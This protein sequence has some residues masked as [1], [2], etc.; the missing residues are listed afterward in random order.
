MTTIDWLKAAM[1]AVPMLAAAQ[2]AWMLYL[3]ETRNERLGWLTALL[4]SLA[5]AISSYR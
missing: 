5:C 2:A 1:I 4:W 3:S